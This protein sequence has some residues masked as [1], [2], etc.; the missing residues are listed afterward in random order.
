[1]VYKTVEGETWDFLA[2]KFYGSEKL[3]YKLLE[4][5]PDLKD[6]VILPAG[7]EVYIPEIEEDI[8]TD[9]ELPPWR[10]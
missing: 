7:A 6:F 4:A 10:R 1:M 5:N 9:M 2:K 8:Q 3:M